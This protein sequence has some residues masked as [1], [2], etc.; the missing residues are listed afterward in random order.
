MKDVLNVEQQIEV[1]EIL[2]YVV[3]NMEEKVMKKIN[4]KKKPTIKEGAL[5]TS[6]Y[7]FLNN[8]GYTKC[9]PEWEHVNKED[10]K[11]MKLK[12]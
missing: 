1:L 8:V 9:R 5:V 12:F 2:W 6:I 3:Q 11:Q 4:N 10:P 7:N